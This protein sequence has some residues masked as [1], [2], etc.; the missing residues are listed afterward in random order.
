M[1]KEDKQQPQQGSSAV[2]IASVRSGG[3]HAERGTSQSSEDQAE[4]EKSVFR[5][6]T[7]YD[8]VWSAAE[9]DEDR[10]RRITKNRGCLKGV[11]VLCSNDLVH[12]S[13]YYV[14]GSLLSAI[15]PIFPLIS[16]Y[17]GSEMWWPVSE[18]GMAR[19]IHAVAYALMA[20][21]GIFYTLGSYA[22]LRAVEFPT[23]PP[24]FPDFYHFQSDE[25]LGMWLMFFGTGTTVP[26]C[27]M[28]AY[29][30]GGSLYWFATA[31]C[32]F[33]TLLFGVA[34]LAC[35]PGLVID[36]EFKNRHDPKQYLQPWITP[37]MP[38]NFCGFNV[39]KHMNNDWLIVSWAMTWGCAGCVFMSLVM[40]VYS[41]SYEKKPRDIYDYATSLVDMILFF[42]GSLYF[43]LGS[44]AQNAEEIR[45]SERKSKGITLGP[46]SVSSPVHEV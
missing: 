20:L 30:G 36:E 37:C 40:M 25:L 16:L 31:C 28:Y 19:D 26:I 9:T 46:S 32:A 38:E 43:A 29:Y 3:S 45:E 2:S 17:L 5:R 27:A 34:T 15:I 24:L 21:L 7:T 23:P 12:G 6:S 10:I 39:K 14:W 22:F 1:Q 11:P 13:W 41:I 18:V 8:D 4:A 33:F 35:Y 42:L 44:Y